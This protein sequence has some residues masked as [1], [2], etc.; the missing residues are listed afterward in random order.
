MQLALR[1]PAGD[2]GCGLKAT[3]AW[4]RSR[5]AGFSEREL[6]NV[7]RAMENAEENA[8]MIDD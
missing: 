7:I 6:E 3:R 4:M 2:D 5:M 1:T 8:G